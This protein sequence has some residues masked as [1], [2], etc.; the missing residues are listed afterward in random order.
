MASVP[1][2]G[3]VRA[4]AA[5][6]GVSPSKSLGQNFMTDPHFLSHIADLAPAPRGGRILEVGP[7]LGSL[8]LPLLERGFE[9]KAVELDSRLAEALPKTVR[10]LSQSSLPRFSCLHKDALNLEEGDL[11]WSGP[12]SLVS[13]LPYSVSV[14]IILH[15]L[16]SFPLLSSFLVLV[17]KE[18]G[19]RLCAK[20]G[21]KSYGVPTLKLAWYGK[22]KIVGKVPRTVFWPA[23][24]VDSVL[25][26]FEREEEEGAL[27]ETTF[28][29]IDAAFRTRRKTLKNSLSPLDAS[30]FEKAGIDPASRPENL[31]IRDFEHIAALLS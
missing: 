26:G 2:A 1:G 29:L 23:P 16:S 11:D 6:L 28:S 3:W 31:S 21:G 25:V 15:L 5:Q 19:E 7:G 10:D 18:V 4:K 22:A 30:V 12:F 24:H 20:T 17:Q 14:P 8:T 27:K 9:V 13:N